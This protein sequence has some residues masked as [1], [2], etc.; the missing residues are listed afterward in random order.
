MY[1]DGIRDRDLAEHIG[2]LRGAFLIPRFLHCDGRFSDGNF[3]R[4]G[5]AVQRVR[6][7]GGERQDR[8]F[9]L[10]NGNIRDVERVESGRLCEYIVTVI[11]GSGKIRVL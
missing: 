9:S 11:R 8:C 10:K 4:A 2:A 6:R 7:H 1:R 3:R 5:I